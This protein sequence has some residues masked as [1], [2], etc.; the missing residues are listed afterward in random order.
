MEIVEG[1]QFDRGH[2]SPYFVTDPERMEGILENPYLIITDKKVSAMADL[3]P[4][5][6][7]I[8][9]WSA[10]LARGRR[11]GRRS[12][13]HPRR[14]QI[15][16]PSALRSCKSSWLSAIAAKRCS[17][18]FILTG[19]I[20]ISEEKGLKL[21]KVDLSSLGSAKRVAVNKT[22]P[23]SMAKERKKI[24][25]LGS[26]RS[27]SRLK[28][29][30]RTSRPETS[31]SVF[32]KMLGGV[33]VINVGA[34]TETEMKTKKFEVEDAMH[35]TRAGV[36]RRMFWRWNRTSSCADRFGRREGFRRR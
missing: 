28:I 30:P 3:L 5:L 34:A 25:K 1:M 7:K 35:A 24:L 8:L 31:K 2:I 29:P 18:T 17:K 22:P 32:A 9:D 16:R 4:L 19:G 26:A 12:L 11:R 20:V 36:E 14:Q 21:D 13:G 15:A 10:V 27:A 33:A 6:E 23:S